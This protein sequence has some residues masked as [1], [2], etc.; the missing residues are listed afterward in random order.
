[1][2]DTERSAEMLK[3]L[4]VL[5][6]DVW[7]EVYGPE[8]RREI[9]RYIT[10]GDK[11]IDAASFRSNYELLSDVDVLLTSWG[12]PRFD[13]ELLKAAPNL[14][15]VFHGAG[16]VRAI[17]TPAFWEKGIPLSS[18]WQGIGDFVADFTIAVAYLSLKNF[19]RYSTDLKQSRSW[20]ASSS[21]EPAVRWAVP[22]TVDTKIGIVGLSAVG[23]SVA[24]RLGNY[25]MK[26]LAYDPY[27]DEAFVR[28][29]NITLTDLATLFAES[30]VVSLHAPSLPETHHMVDRALLTSM[31]KGATLVN[32][33]RGPLVDHA[34]L[35]DVLKER[36]DLYAV[37]DVTDPEP[38]PAESPLFELPNV[39][40]TPH[41]AAQLGRERR[42]LGRL[43]VEEVRRFVQG[44]PLQFAVDPSV[45][46]V[47]A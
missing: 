33:A 18:T 7:N 27:A 1:M 31:K 46:G 15:A 29:H 38:L 6:N 24:R 22:G 2:V 17:A 45:Q 39:L 23:K 28:D 42:A 4:Y 43:V 26:A 35:Y 34:A 30:D 19:W 3:G 13:E 5:D 32:T 37:L 9:E 20:V 16:S 21:L 11:Q 44:K 36:P 25:H 8:E 41:I 14:K 47:S 40:M 12:A 10:T